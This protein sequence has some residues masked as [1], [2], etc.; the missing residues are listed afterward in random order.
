MLSTLS[1]LSNLYATGYGTVPSHCG[2]H[3]VTSGRAGFRIFSFAAHS[4]PNQ[5]NKDV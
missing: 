4:V 3:G 2:S 1:T 5:D